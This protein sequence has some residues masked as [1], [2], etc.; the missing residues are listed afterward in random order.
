MKEARP[1]LEIEPMCEVCESKEE[2]AKY[3][4]KN[5]PIVYDERKNCIIDLKVGG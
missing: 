3:L 4:R 1:V 2:C 5:I